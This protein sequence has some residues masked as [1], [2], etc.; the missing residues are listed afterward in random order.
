MAKLSIVNY[1]DKHSL[2]EL[3]TPLTSTRL[4]PPPPRWKVFGGWGAAVQLRHSSTSANPHA[5]G[6][7]EVHAV[8]YA[9]MLDFR[10]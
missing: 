1:T 6:R 7:G 2:I 10:M 8:P 5:V 4:R 3:G 9:R